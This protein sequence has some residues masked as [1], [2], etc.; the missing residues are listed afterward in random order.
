MLRKK[1]VTVTAQ[2]QAAIA[3]GV[4]VEQALNEHGIPVPA[5]ESTPPTEPAVQAPAATDP[6]AEGAPAAVAEPE[7]SGEPVEDPNLAEAS[8]EEAVTLE[9]VSEDTALTSVLD[10]LQ[11][12][13][14]EVA[15]Q[16]AKIAQLEATAEQ[17]QAN[18]TSLM[19][20]TV[21]ATNI[22]QIALGGTALDLTHLDAT[23]LLAQ[24]SST[25]T[26]FET[27]LP[28]GAQAEVPVEDDDRDGKVVTLVSP[29]VARAT[30]IRKSGGTK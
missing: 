12:A 18:Q 3:A 11:V 20:V 29:A 14:N 4:P 8:S 22:M 13:Q 21:K 26:T 10:R 15:T 27:K 2:A 9:V 30:Q 5:A 7:T 17:M 16:A 1:R 24:Y 19:A 28:V 25:L 6:P 23:S